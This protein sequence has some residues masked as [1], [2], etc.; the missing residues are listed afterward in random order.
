M[1]VF[2]VASQLDKWYLSNAKAELPLSCKTDVQMA[3]GFP[4]ADTENKYVGLFKFKV[5]Q[6]NLSTDFI[7]DTT[8]STIVLFDLPSNSPTKE[9]VYE[10]YKIAN[11]NANKIVSE[12]AIFSKI[13]IN[14]EWPHSP[15]N[16]LER[17]IIDSIQEMFYD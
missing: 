3:L 11:E 13:E 1:T 4:E 16:I 15:Y 9:N 10:L 2:K 6:T 8:V 12:Q 7:I 5:Y 14:I 17:I